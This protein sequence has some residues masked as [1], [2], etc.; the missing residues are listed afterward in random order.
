MTALYA[1]QAATKYVYLQ[2]EAPHCIVTRSTASMPLT[3]G[4][5]AKIHPNAKQPSRKKKEI[6][7]RNDGFPS[8]PDL[9]SI[10]PQRTSSNQGHLYSFSKISCSSLV[11]TESTICA[12]LISREAALSCLPAYAIRRG[13]SSVSLQ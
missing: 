13:I 8:T 11:P 5:R 10:P 6:V 4:L 2:P 3:E 12:V 1:A 9:L 7:K